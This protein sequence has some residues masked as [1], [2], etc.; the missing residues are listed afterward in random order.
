V[1]TLICKSCSRKLQIRDEFAGQTGQCPACGS[2][3]D[4]PGPEPGPELAPLTSRAVELTAELPDRP[5]EVSEPE[6]PSESQEPL[7]DHG[8]GGLP[9]G[10][11]F[12]A[13]VPEEIGPLRSAHTTLLQGQYPKPMSGRLAGAT[14]LGGVGVAIGLLIVVGLQV[15]SDFWRGFWPI[16]LGLGCFGLVMALTGFNHTCTYVGRDGVVR[17]VCSG[18][19]D[20]LTTQE[21]FRFRDAADLRTS[22]TLRY[23]NGAYQNTTYAY[24]W[25][26]I[27]G[28]ER[29]AIRGSHNS[30]AGTPASTDLYHYAKAS[31]IAWTIYLFGAAYSQLEL[32]SSVLFNLTG[33]QWIRLG[34]GVI[35]FGMGGEPEQWRADEVRGAT[36]QKGVV[37]IMRHDAKEGWFSSSGLHKFSF[38]QL[39]NAQLFFHMLD[40]VVGIPVN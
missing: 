8:G 1:I 31:E 24:T 22:I 23:T 13:P 21:V 27:G 16:A 35:I 6:P 36:I 19:R 4:I 30:E 2:T 25:T 7:L 26:D 12:F 29:Y 15:H 10:A 37:K 14:V 28:R 11:D 20:N 32:G 3:L 39:G 34:H 33:G 9:A 5:Q 38:D 40:K 18:S 17:F